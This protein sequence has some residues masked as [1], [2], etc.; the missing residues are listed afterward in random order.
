MGH[1]RYPKLEG[2]SEERTARAVIRDVPMSFKEA[3][4]VC[5]VIRGMELSKAKE[6]LKRVIELKEPIPYTRYK[7][8]IGHKRGLASRWSDFKSPIGRYPVKVAKN[9]LKLLE[10][11]ENNAISKGLNAEKL[12]I[13]HIAAHRGYYLKKWMPRAFGRATP[14]FRTHTSVE[15]IVAEV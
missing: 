3:Y 9:I 1:W 6:L 13:V 11:V 10:N 2:V 4:E 5:K 8:S 14:W 7:L 12:K 15:V